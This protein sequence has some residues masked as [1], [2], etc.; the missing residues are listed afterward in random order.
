MLPT[1]SAHFPVLPLLSSSNY[2]PI[3]PDRAVFVSK[4]PGPTLV[5]PGG[6]QEIFNLTGSILVS[7]FR[8]QQKN[9]THW[10]RVSHKM[11]C[12]SPVLASSFSPVQFKIHDLALPDT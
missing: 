2:T 1:E 8:C 3:Q 9:P 10:V 4:D 7:G 11:D 6:V 12:L 5:N